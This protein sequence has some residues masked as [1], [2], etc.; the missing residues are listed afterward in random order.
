MPPAAVT[1]ARRGNRAGGRSADWYRLDPA[2]W[3][4]LLAD[5]LTVA[6]Y[7]AKVYRRAPGLCWPWL[8]AISGSGHARLRA[9]TRATGTGRPPSRVVAAH[10]FGWQ[11]S[12]G[13]LRPGADGRLPV[14]RHRCD[15][16][17]CLNPVHWLTGTTADNSADY[18]DR[19]GDPCSPLMDLRGARG[20]A[21]AIR[22]AVL[23]SLAAGDV[24]E[25]TE[26][27]IWRA[28]AAG[29]RGQQERLF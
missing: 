3:R 2:Q 25:Q 18:H 22:D 24:P 5:P 1:S 28:V 6:S 26:H 20:R 10:V 4:D 17:A 19:A 29:S 16:P 15:F 8:G 23:A 13:P 21:T 11:L 14:I 7:H 9:G 27:A 12:R